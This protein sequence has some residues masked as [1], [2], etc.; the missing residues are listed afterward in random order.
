MWV[1][2]TQ[3]C[4]TLWPHELYSP[5]NS[6]GQNTRVGSLSLLQRIFP[7]QGSNGCLLH[8]RQILYQLN[9]QESLN[10]EWSVAFSETFSELGNILVSLQFSES[11][12]LA[13]YI[14]HVLYIYT[15]GFSKIWLEIQ[16]SCALSAKRL[17][18]MIMLK[19]MYWAFFQCL[20][21]FQWVPKQCL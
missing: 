12:Y 16:F 18:E 3:L 5:W 7:T 14:N 10:S 4:P 2:V 6:P 15:Y 20:N 11:C 8:C 17:Y 13:V 21:F 9:Y 1:K 19:Q